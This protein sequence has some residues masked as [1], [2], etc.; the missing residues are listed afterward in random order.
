MR[1][2]AYEKLILNPSGF[3]M[4]INRKHKY[5]DIASDLLPQMVLSSFKF[6][7]M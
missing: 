1:G 6:G 7:A 2:T 5:V 3:G 4:L